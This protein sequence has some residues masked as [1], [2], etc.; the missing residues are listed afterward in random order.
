VAGAGRPSGTRRTR[1]LACRQRAGQCRLDRRFR[2]VAL[3]PAGA[4]AV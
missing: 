2:P 1:M 4:D 3:A